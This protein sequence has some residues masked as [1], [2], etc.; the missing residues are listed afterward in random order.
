[1]K[2][3]THQFYTK[4]SKTRKQNKIRSDV[5]SEKIRKAKTTKLQFRRE[6]EVISVV[7]FSLKYFFKLDEPNYHSNA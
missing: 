1:M 5:G 7:L 3:R 6:R 4:N 2:V